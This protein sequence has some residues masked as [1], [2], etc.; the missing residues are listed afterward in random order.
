MLEVP[1]ST[2]I[3]NSTQWTSGKLFGSFDLPNNLPP[4][5]Y[6]LR[7]DFGLK[8]GSRYV[9]FNNNTI[10]T[11]PQSLNSISCAYSPQIEASGWDVNGNWVDA[12]T[13]T[14]KPY[15]VLLWDYN[16]N[17]YRGVVAREDEGR[18]AISPR[19]LIHDDI[20]LPRVNFNCVA[21]TYNLEP[22]F[23]LEND[24]TQRSIPWQYK[25]GQNLC[26]CFRREFPEFY[27]HLVPLGCT[28]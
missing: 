11:R 7:L 2:F 15:W 25:S 18:V 12:S 21:L 24:N 27:V 17:G 10:G 23:L 1:L 26:R 13:I 28:S 5:I 22:M 16:S 6:R 14:R 8:S 9:D 20:I 19:N 3:L 4:G